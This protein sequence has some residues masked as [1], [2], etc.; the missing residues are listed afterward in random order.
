MFISIFT[1][2]IIFND[3]F[4]LVPFSLF[5]II[6]VGNTI[7][8][9]KLYYNGSYNEF[10]NSVVILVVCAL[11][12]VLLHMIINYKK[13]KELKLKLFW[14]YI[15][16][17][18]VF[19]L[20]LVN[21][22]DLNLFSIGIGI[23]LLPFIMYFAYKLIDVNDDYLDVLSYLMLL[24]VL[25]IAYQLYEVIL[26][27]QTANILEFIMFHGIRLNYAITNDYASFVIMVLPFIIY[28]ASKS[29]LPV[30]SYV[31]FIIGVAVVF[32]SHSRNGFGAVLI[33]LPLLLYLV[34]RYSKHRV[35]NIIQLLIVLIICYNLIN[36]WI[37]NDL[38]DNSAEL[39]LSEL[40]KF[41]DRA[42]LMDIGLEKWGEHKILGTGL[43]SANTFLQKENGS[44]F[45]SYHSSF[46]DFLSNNGIVGLLS[47]IYFLLVIYIE[48]L[49]K[50]KNPFNFTALVSLII[51]IPFWLFNTQHQN[52]I[53]LIILMIIVAA[54]EGSNKKEK[55]TT[56]ND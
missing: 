36:H 19:I 33:S 17:F 39:F 22:E 42:K 3:S 43:F 4:Y 16:M 37:P 54:V 1:T 28:L 12:T 52:P 5:G 26:N 50:L 53:N 2:L 6:G 30:F 48:P 15:F 7:D 14:P 47:W 56:I 13:Y 38:M 10:F 35:L 11:I 23:Y 51:L 25:A 27:Y 31:V 21:T 20:S 8:F 9:T 44:P 29:K 34:L 41:S 46:I 40:M 24:F 32:V 55:S 45:T 49:K 18:I